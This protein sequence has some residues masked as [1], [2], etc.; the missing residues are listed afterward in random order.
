LKGSG[1]DVTGGMV[2][3]VKK[4]LQIAKL[5]VESEII[6]AAKPDVLKRALLGEEGLGTIIRR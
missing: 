2:L 1:I 4:L 5:G 6:N 3:K